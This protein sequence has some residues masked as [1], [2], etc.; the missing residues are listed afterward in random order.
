MDNLNLK[1][2]R[3]VDARG[4]QRWRL[5]GQL[6][7]TD[8][9]AVVWASGTQEW[10]VNDQRHRTDGPA[11]MLVSGYHAW[12]IDDKDITKQVKKWMKDRDISW[13]FSDEETRVEFVLTFCG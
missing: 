8:G 11:L 2:V 3:R 6:H 4:N 5:N 7:R 1:P 13:P 10:W 12:F 9:P